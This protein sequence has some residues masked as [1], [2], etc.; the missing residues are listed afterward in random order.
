MG[1]GAGGRMGKASKRRLLIVRSGP[2]D[3]DLV[4]RLQGQ[5]DLPLAESARSQVLAGLRPVPISPEPLAGIYSAPDEASRACAE[6][7]VAETE[8][9]GHVEEDLRE[10]NMGLWTGLR[11]EELESRF[12]RAGTQWLNDPAS[13]SIPEGEAF[14]DFEARILGVLDK[15]LVKKRSALSVAVVLRP[16]AH[17]MLLGRLERTGTAQMG[18]FLG[19]WESVGPMWF[20]VIRG[21]PRLQLVPAESAHG[22][23]HPEP[24]GAREAGKGSSAAVNRQTPAA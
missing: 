17:A 2:T 3:W 7:L 19:D 13:V 18:R 1:D 14:I 15:V 16:V 23:A 11:I 12:E 20:D 8:A 22:A 9:R 6:A 4:G 24:G 10:L 5:T 21:D